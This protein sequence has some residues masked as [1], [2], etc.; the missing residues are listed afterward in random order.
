MRAGWTSGRQAA[1]HLASTTDAAPTSA[2]S[3]RC[4]TPQPPPSTNAPRAQLPHPAGVALHHILRLNP[5]PQLPP[6]N[7]RS[8][9]IAA[10]SSRSRFIL[11]SSVA[12]SGSK[13][14]NEGRGRKNGTME[15]HIYI[16]TW[17]NGSC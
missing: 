13:E 10:S 17:P 4:P 7:R 3:G 5:R 8:T 11:A 9:P 2:S 14:E 16:Q 1:L 6:Y 15:G 12:V